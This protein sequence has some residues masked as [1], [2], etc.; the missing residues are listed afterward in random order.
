[1]SEWYYDLDGE[2]QGPVSKEVLQA[3]F[4]SAELPPSNLVWTKDMADWQPA[5]EVEGLISIATPITPVLQS[6]TLDSVFSQSDEIPESEEEFS[7]Y[8]APNSAEELPNSM[9]TGKMPRTYLVQSIILTALT[10]FCCCCI[11]LGVIPLVYSVMVSN[12]YDR[13]DYYGSKAASGTAK[14]WCII[15]WIIVGIRIL[16]Q[17]L[18]LGIGF[19]EGFNE[20]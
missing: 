10:F 19:V 7:P 3:K 9:L 18:G 20:W 11:P 5:S 16:I 2:Q 4:V 8:A 17:F 13:G 1:M 14:V 12:R 15:L 6:E